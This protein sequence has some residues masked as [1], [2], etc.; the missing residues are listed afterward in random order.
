MNNTNP[1]LL[2]GAIAAA[3]FSGTTVAEN[4]TTEDGSPIIVITSANRFAQPVSSVLAPVEVV[5]QQ[6]MS[7]WQVTSVTEALRRLPGVQI[8]QNGG[9]GQLSTVF[10]RGNE[11]RHVLV[12]IDGIRV[13]QSASGTGS[14]DFNQLPLALVERIEYIRGPRSSTYGADAIGGV[15][16]II[17]GRETDGGN[18]QASAGSLHYQNYQ[19]SV[20]RKLGDNTTVSI[21]GQFVDTS[22]YDVVGSTNP[23]QPD[24]DGFRNRFG[25]GSVEH[26]FSDS[27]SGFIRVHG[28]GGMREYDGSTNENHT[29]TRQYDSGLR[30]NQNN[31]SSQLIASYQDIDSDTFKLDRSSTHDSYNQR[32]L[33]WM[34]NYQIGSGQIG[35]GI[36]WNRNQAFVSSTPQQ[37]DNTGIY[38][39]AQQVLDKWTVEGAIR[40]DHN[41]DYGNNF[42]WQSGIG[43]QFIENAQAILSYG[44]AFKAPTLSQ[45]YGSQ[46]SKPSP[47]LEAETSK[48]VELALNG[49]M[50]A[51]SWR[52][53]GYRNDIDNLITQPERDGIYVNTKYAVIKGIETELS[54]STSSSMHSLSFDYTDPRD[55]DGKLLLRRAQHTYKYM[56]DFEVMRTQFNIAYQYVGKRDDVG[57][58]KLPSYSLWD[59]AASY[60]ITQSFTARGRIA[61]LF[62]KKYETAYGYPAAERAYYLTLS[63]DF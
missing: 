13:A 22:G 59:L 40:Q 60:P 14:V 10:I 61:N 23:K 8:S 52:I 53:A 36:D 58:K 51:L 43:W 2:A 62:D 49:Q 24:R 45:Q 42:T 28:S 15:I 6:E 26:N 7:R 33:Q 9:L 16:N 48:N 30:F 18:L 34:N 25:W 37:R 32:T 27:T 21:A 39:T 31:Y 54:Y 50:N 56:L 41:Q 63:Y 29:Y 12:L 1:T 38:I 20:R 46:Y 11:S 17:T 57:D 47:N 35:A 55:Q 5:T 44:T 4:R 19:G 3:L